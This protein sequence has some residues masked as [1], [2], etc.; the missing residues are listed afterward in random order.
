MSTVP[1]RY[2]QGPGGSAPSGAPYGQQPYGWQP[3]HQQPPGQS[4]YGPRP[5]GPYPSA[6]PLSPSDERLWATLAH[7]LPVAGVGFVA[8]LVIWLLYRE[9]SAFVD[10]EAKEALNFQIFLVVAAVVIG[11]V[12]LA[13]FGIGAFLY[14]GFVAAFV[15]MIQAGVA[16]NQGRPYRYPVTWRV[17]R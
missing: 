6:P 12:A 14:L 3:Y 10:Q 13:T 16:T 11:V 1:P 2:G 17:I 5:G 8:P 9:R 15:F 4:P 7:V